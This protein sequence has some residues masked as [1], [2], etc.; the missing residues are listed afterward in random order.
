MYVCI[1]N[2]L[3]E[4]DVRQTARATGS[5]SAREVYRHLGCEFQCGLCKPVARQMIGEEISDNLVA[6]P[7]MAMA[8]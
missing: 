8:V 1:C 4:S 6:E 3:K 7:A 5:D 2:A